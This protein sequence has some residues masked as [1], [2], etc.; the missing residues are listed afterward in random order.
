MHDGGIIFD[1]Q[2]KIGEVPLRARSGG[3]AIP[4]TDEEEQL[5]GVSLFMAAIPAKAPPSRKTLTKKPAK[6]AGK[7][8]KK[9]TSSKKPVK[10]T[11]AKS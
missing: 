4:K 11:K 6:K 9:T 1:E 7:K 5:E 8:A 3:E 10:K 2:T